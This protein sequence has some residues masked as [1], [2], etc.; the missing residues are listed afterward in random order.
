VARLAG[1]SERVKSILF[2]RDGKL[3]IAG[4]RTRAESGEVQYGDAI[5]RKLRNAQTLT[6]EAVS[7]VSLSP[8]RR[9]RCCWLCGWND[10]ACWR[11]R[12]AK[13]SVANHE[14]WVLG[15][16]F[17]ADGTRVI[18]VGRDGTGHVQ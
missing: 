6:N 2:S 18:S 14:N 1:L 16:A 4:A 10:A 17:S 7:G 5:G 13:V 8:G 12:R 9:A 15:T 11:P 3:L